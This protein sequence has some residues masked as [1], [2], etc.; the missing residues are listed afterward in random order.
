[1]FFDFEKTPNLKAALDAAYLTD[2]IKRGVTVWP[3]E[4]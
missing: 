1:M 4:N 2:K 3:R